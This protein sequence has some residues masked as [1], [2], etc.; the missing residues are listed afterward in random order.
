MIAVLKKKALPNHID[1]SNVDPPE[2]KEGHLIVRIQAAGVCGSDLHTYHWTADYQRRLQGCLPVILG[3][4]FAGVIEEIGEGVDGFSVGDRIISRPG[5]N[6][7]ECY[8]CLEGHDGICVNRKVMGVHFNGAMAEK[9]L[10]PAANCH[11][12]SD[13]I[14]DTLAMM[15]EPITIAYNAVKKAGNLLGK[16]AVTFGPGP[17]G[18]LICLFLR[19][20]G[21]RNYIIAGLEKDRER[22]EIFKN[23]LDGIE[24]LDNTE[25]L[26]CRIA[27][28]SQGCGAHAA[29]DA[30]GSGTGFQQCLESVRK[31]GVVVLVGVI[32]DTIS[33]DSNLIVRKEVMV[34]GSHAGGRALWNEVIAY[35]ESLSDGE[36][37]N[38]EK[39]MTHRFSLNDAEAAFRS[40]KKGIGLKTA[41]IPIA[42]GHK[43]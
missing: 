6:C 36:M 21:V 28:M 42:G 17:I 15:I 9:I 2:L 23:N 18:Y 1:V 10:V 12:I 22:L 37:S 16:C 31:R 8:C 19:R 43:S 11:K 4:E 33:I 34:R 30:S 41:L 3:H 13:K 32:A 27:N 14:S 35:L 25:N 38:F 29:F 20:A 5:I 7:G 39:G 40:V 26:S 24:I